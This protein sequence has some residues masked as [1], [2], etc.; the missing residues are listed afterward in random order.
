MGF[1]SHLFVFFFAGDNWRQYAF[2]EVAGERD[3][4]KVLRAL[5]WL[6]LPKPLRTQIP[7]LCARG[8]FKFRHKINCIVF[9]IYIKSAITITYEIARVIKSPNIFIYNLTER[10][11]R[12]FRLWRWCDPK[13]TPNMLIYI[14]IYIYKHIEKIKFTF[15]IS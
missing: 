15:T 13:H 5:F 8:R 11:W 10:V 9:Y 1:V 7:Y 6:R 2:S 4:L 3:R 14:Y 12:M